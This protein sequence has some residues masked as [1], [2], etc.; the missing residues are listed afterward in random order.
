[1]QQVSLEKLEFFAYHGFHA[2]ERQK[3]NRFEVDIYVDLD[4][5]EASKRDSIK[6]TVNYQNLYE[7]VREEM[8][9]KSKLLENV[10]M[11]IMRRVFD[12]FPQVQ[13]VEVSVSKFN[14]PLG[15]ICQRS[16]IRIREE[17]Q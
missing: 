17:R 8:L 12:E 9:I 2:A 11:R 16:R 3:G 14:P 6:G 4:F 1:M 10:A 7:I 15:G 13:R 5:S